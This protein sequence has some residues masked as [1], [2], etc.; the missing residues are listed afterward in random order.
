MEVTHGSESCPGAGTRSFLTGKWKGLP[1]FLGLQYCNESS[2]RLHNHML[3]AGLSQGVQVARKDGCRN[4]I[5]CVCGA[6]S[7]NVSTNAKTAAFIKLAQV[8][9]NANLRALIQTDEALQGKYRARLE[10]CVRL[11]LRLG[12]VSH[13]KSERTRVLLG[14]SL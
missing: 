12:G 8:R 5:H 4:R 1:G 9:G 14:L 7:A 13:T 3:K 6:V 10:R 2:K 11:A